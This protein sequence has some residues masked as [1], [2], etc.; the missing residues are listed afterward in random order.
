[1]E[2][3]ISIITL[4]VIDLERSFRFYKEGLGFL[5]QGKLEE[6]IIFFQTSGT[7]LGLYPLDKLPEDVS[8][9]ISG[10]RSGFPGITLSHNT[11]TKEEVDQVLHLAE[12]AGGVIVKPAQMVF[13]GG[14]SGYFTDQD[15][16]Y[17]EVAW[18]EFWELNP[19]GSLVV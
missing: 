4:G 9:Q 10:E 1:M 19:D 6:G 5:T 15:G 16:Y 12:K 3:R 13:W 7:R 17:W 18:A 2:A 11:R 8:P 14:Y